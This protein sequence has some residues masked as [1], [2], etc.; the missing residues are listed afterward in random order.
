ML[1]DRPGAVVYP[2]RIVFL[3]LRGFVWVKLVT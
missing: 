1:D 2:Q 3:G